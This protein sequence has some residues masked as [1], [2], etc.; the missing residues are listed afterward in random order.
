MFARH[1]EAVSSD[2]N[3][4]L[5]FEIAKIELLKIEKQLLTRDTLKEFA[6]L[7]QAINSHQSLETLNWKISYV[8][9]NAMYVIW[10]FE[11]KCTR[12][13]CM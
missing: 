13:G 9:E 5:K 2:R 6:R 10:N 3:W 8:I 12:A 4:Y 11:L 7:N 1:K